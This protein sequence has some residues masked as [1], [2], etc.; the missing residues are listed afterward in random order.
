MRGNFPQYS[1]SAKQGD[2]GI[3]IVSRIVTDNFGWIF[4]RNHQEYDFGI[5]GQ[6]EVITDDGN[7]TGQVLAVQ[8]K[9]GKSF[10]KNKNRF[11][12]K[13]RGETKHFN[14]LANYPIPVLIILCDPDTKDA[15]WELF[16][17]LS[18]QQM[19]SSWSMTIPDYRLLSMSKRAIIDILPPLIN[20]ADLLQEYWEMNQLIDST[21]YIHLI[22]DIEDVIQ[23]N[24]G[25]VRAFFDRLCVSKEVAFSAHGKVVFSVYGYEEDEREL[26]EIEEVRQ[27]FQQLS[28]E[29][30]ELFFFVQATTLPHSIQLFAF[31]YTDIKFVKYDPKLN[32]RQVMV[33]TKKIAEFL[34]KNFPGL[35][36]MTNWLNM[37]EHENKV[38]CYNIGTSIGLE[39]PPHFKP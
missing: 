14:Y 5:D 15:Y 27:Y 26:Y 30:P 36:K 4:K 7:V 18:T 12:Y 20:S 33:D 22:V 24:T 1:N 25:R 37:S 34:W 21:D 35:N 10:L 23:K 31:C 8:I 6:I 13:Y 29:L 38:I 19:D 39:L 32:R 2:Q 17:P 28:S 16:K 9:C 11:G 3:Q